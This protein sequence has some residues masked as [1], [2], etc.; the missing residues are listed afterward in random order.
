VP[1]AASTRTAQ[2]EQ[3]RRRFIAVVPTTGLVRLTH[4]ILRRRAGRVCSVGKV[5][6][7]YRGCSTTALC[8]TYTDAARSQD[9]AQGNRSGYD[10][11][12]RCL[13]RIV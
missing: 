7:C 5:D 6:A 4:Q 11:T 3:I 12:H 13:S 2:Q 10:T 9:A 1:R 8:Q